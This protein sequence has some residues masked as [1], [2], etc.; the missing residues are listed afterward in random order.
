MVSP[1]TVSSQE[2]TNL[3]ASLK[4]VYFTPRDWEGGLYRLLR[5]NRFRQWLITSKYSPNIG[6]RDAYLTHFLPEN[7]SVPRWKQVQDFEELSK[8]N[9][10][11]HVSKF[12]VFQYLWITLGIGLGIV[13]HPVAGA[14]IALAGEASSV[15]SDLYP[16]MVQRETR[17]RIKKIRNRFKI[18]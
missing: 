8:R 12:V 4:N 17:L 16:I 11:G 1:E 15:A 7:Q 9:E 3:V 5:V 2:S 13:I 10:W 18:N 6:R 14:T